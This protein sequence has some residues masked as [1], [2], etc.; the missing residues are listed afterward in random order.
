LTRRL[1][2]QVS[3]TYYAKSF[4]NDHLVWTKVRTIWAKR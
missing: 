3:E 2:A 1:T 4:A